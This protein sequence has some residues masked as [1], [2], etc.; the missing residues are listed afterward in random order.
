MRTSY[1]AGV[2][3]ANTHLGLFKTSGFGNVQEVL[4]SSTGDAGRVRHRTND[5]PKAQART[6]FQNHDLHM[7]YPA[8]QAT[9][10]SVVGKSQSK[11]AANASGYALQGRTTFQGLKISIEQRKG[12][13]RKWKDEST[14][15]EGSTKMLHPYGYIRMSEGTDGDHVDVYLGPNEDATHAYI[16]N[17]M[18]KPKKEKKVWSQFDEQK[19]M[20]GF[21]NATEAKNAYL[22]Q[23]SDSRFFGSMKKMPMSEFKTKVLSRKY[24]GKKLGSNYSESDYQRPLQSNVST[25]SETV[26]GDSLGVLGRLRNSNDSMPGG[27]REDPADQISRSFNAMDTGEGVRVLDGDTAATPASPGV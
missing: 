11:E 8:S 1:L 14:G 12:A 4:T 17:Q 21:R 22:A 5:D 25:T 13:V 2:F 3:A 7:A 20:L 18:R 16:V 24:W 23:Y 15:E 10:V 19:V 9:E 6:A 26:P 27:W